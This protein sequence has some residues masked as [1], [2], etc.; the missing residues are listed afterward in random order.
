M[1]I[2]EQNRDLEAKL[3]HNKKLRGNEEM[4]EFIHEGNWNLENLYA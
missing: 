4:V 1:R 2:I 3:V